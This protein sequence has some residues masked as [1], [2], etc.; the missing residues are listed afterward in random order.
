M[1]MLDVTFYRY[2]T[3]LSN[4]NIPCKMKLDIGM[5]ESSVTSGE[6][7][8]M[9]EEEGTGES[10]VHKLEEELME[11]EKRIK[12]KSELLSMNAKSPL[13]EQD[14]MTL[15]REMMCRAEMS[16]DNGKGQ[17]GQKME[18]VPKESD[19]HERIFGGIKDDGEKDGHILQKRNRKARTIT[20]KTLVQNECAIDAKKMDMKLR[21]EKNLKSDHTIHPSGVEPSA[22]K[23]VAPKQKEFKHKSHPS[24]AELFANSPYAESMRCNGVNLPRIKPCSKVP[25][26][27]IFPAAQKR[28]GGCK[29]PPIRNPAQ[30]SQ[31][32]IYTA[33]DSS[34]S[35]PV[36]MAPPMRPRTQAGHA[37]GPPLSRRSTS[38]NRS[39]IR[40]PTSTPSTPKITPPLMTIPQTSREIRNHFQAPKRQAGMG[41]MA[42]AHPC[43]I[44]V[45]DSGSKQLG[46]NSSNNCALSV[47][48]GVKFPPMIKLTPKSQSYPAEIKEMGNEVA[49]NKS[50]DSRGRAEKVSRARRHGQQ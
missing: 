3:N 49:D 35:T 11:I 30:V 1:F 44:L 10:R 43:N 46:R 12:E 36:S 9:I 45:V 17:K 20:N 13:T 29:L 27:P 5:M 40:T 22:K 6:R 48:G 38:Q 18:T 37:A 16:L 14:Y 23:H 47:E 39:L 32:A 33:S 4:E 8:G 2:G 41:K 25:G 7:G 28:H 42:V 31:S 50:R 15:L 21:N 34:H 24:T 26:E 19:V